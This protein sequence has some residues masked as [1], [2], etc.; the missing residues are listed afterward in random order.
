MFNSNPFKW[1]NYEYRQKQN[2]GQDM[3]S[4]DSQFWTNAYKLGPEAKR[5]DISKWGGPKRQQE[6]L[7]RLYAQQQMF[8]K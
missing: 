7:A 1:Q 6:G 5:D 2:P 8:R 4:L 3:G